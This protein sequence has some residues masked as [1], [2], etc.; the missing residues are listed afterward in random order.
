MTDLIVAKMWLFV[1]SPDPDV[2]AQLDTR[3]PR[4]L[5]QKW[6]NLAWDK[7]VAGFSFS[8]VLNELLTVD[9]T[10]ILTASG[11]DGDAVSVNAFSSFTSTGTWSNGPSGQHELDLAVK[12]QAST[13]GPTTD[14]FWKFV[15][16]SGGKEEVRVR[17]QWSEIKIP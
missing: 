2:Q 1:G 12:Y 8:S 5:E 14:K 7:D 3:F 11:D 10:S 17:L 15:R 13:G 4:S 9:V 16:T 6:L